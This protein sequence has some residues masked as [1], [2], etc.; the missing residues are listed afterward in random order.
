MLKAM[1]TTEPWTAA[2]RPELW[3]DAKVVNEKD[4]PLATVH[5]PAGNTHRSKAGIDLAQFASNRSDW[6]D[7]ARRQKCEPRY[8]RVTRLIALDQCLA[9]DCLKCLI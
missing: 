9:A 4:A 3:P 2:I 8:H 6:P 1:S 7:R 5:S